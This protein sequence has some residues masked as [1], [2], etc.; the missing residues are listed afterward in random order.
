M[1]YCNEDSEE[2]ITNNNTNASSAAIMSR[3]EETNSIEAN[4]NKE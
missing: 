3:N 1:M 2:N 4:V